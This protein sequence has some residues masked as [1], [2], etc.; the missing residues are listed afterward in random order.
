MKQISYMN[1]EI[2]K[3]EEWIMKNSNI[4]K[5]GL[6]D[7]TN[8]ANEIPPVQEIAMF[9]ACFLTIAKQVKM[10]T[11]ICTNIQT[12][13]PVKKTNLDISKCFIYEAVM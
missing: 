9:A 2:I 4:K 12:F 11:Y 10:C 3:K 1:C 5:R 7:L 6:Q 8:Y 13:N